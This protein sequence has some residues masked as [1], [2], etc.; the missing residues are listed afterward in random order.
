[1]L[2]SQRRNPRFR[3]LVL[4]S[5]LAGCAAPDSIVESKNTP[6]TL[7]ISAARPTSTRYV[8]EEVGALPGDVH[9]FANG[10]NDLGYVVGI[11]E[12]QPT[13]SFV[14][15]HAFLK[16]GSTM[17]M[18]S[19][20]GRAEAV[21]NTYPLYIVGADTH[22]GTDLPAR[23]T[24][25][26]A[27]A[28]PTVEVFGT[29][30]GDAVDVNDAGVAIGTAQQRA[31]VWAVDGSEEVIEPTGAYD[32]TSGRG[33]NNSGHI[34]VGFYDEEGDDRAFLRVDGTWIE[35]P[36]SGSYPSSY[37]SDLSNPVNGIVYVSGVSADGVTNTDYHLTR[38][39]VNV[40][41]KQLINTER[42]KEISEGHGVSDAGALGGQAE[43]NSTSSGFLWTLTDAIGLKPTRGGSSPQITD[44]SP[45][46][47]YITGNAAYGLQFRGVLWVLQSP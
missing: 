27:G 10:V 46:G 17:T 42:K 20:A 8:A 12:P 37:A 43:K 45:N 39:T 14:P 3:L 9:A 18:I 41:T 11:S 5:I 4:A 1:M 38:W 47:L 19:N 16:T 32:R 35:L 22:T 34:C 36:P 6:A 24:I 2:Q 33:I 15:Y 44:V 7:E 31:R 28:S 30:F 13:G 21:S 29:S 23:W 25:A 26:T 40:T